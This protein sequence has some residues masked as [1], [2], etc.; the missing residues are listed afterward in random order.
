LGFEFPRDRRLR[1][2]R[3]FVHVQQS[4]RRIDGRHFVVLVARG[5]GRVGITVSRKVGNAVTR[6]RIKRLVREFA[7]Q[8]ERTARRWPPLDVDAV[9]VARRGA[10]RVTY[11]ALVSELSRVGA[12]L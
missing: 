4:G 11:A 6:N 8:A 7:R 10:A 2:A 12:R 1:K 9:V 3:D 5:G